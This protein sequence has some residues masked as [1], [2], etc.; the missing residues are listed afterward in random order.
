MRICVVSIAF[1]GCRKSTA[2]PA[3]TPA[4][5]APKTRKRGVSTAGST[6]GATVTV[7][8]SSAAV[9][10]EL[11]ALEGT[12]APLEVVSWAGNFSLVNLAQFQG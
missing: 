6:A 2:A 11:A 12:D 9:T 1:F 10:A 8:T 4:V 7:G 3:A 5:L